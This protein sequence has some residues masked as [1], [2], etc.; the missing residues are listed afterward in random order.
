[1]GAACPKCGGEM[2]EGRIP[3]ALKFLFGYRSAAQRHF[4]WECNIQK[5][6]ACLGCGYL[7]LFLD[8]EEIKS[9]MK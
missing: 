8:P 3:I 6:R 1:M 4:S 2:D 5:A 7:E 9:K